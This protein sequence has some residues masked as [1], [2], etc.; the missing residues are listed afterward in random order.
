MAGSRPQPGRR[1]GLGLALVVLRGV[2]AAFLGAAAMLF[3]LHGRG[4]FARFGRPDEARIALACAEILGSALFVLSRTALAGGV[5]LL[6]V[7]AWAAGFHYALAQSAERLWMDAA[8][9]AALLAATYFREARIRR[10][11]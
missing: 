8:A 9:V 1:R 3:L 6:G 7:L 11:A 2:V 4:A 10:E 5:V